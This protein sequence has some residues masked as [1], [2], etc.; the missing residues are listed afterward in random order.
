MIAKIQRNL[1]KYYDDP[2][3]MQKVSERVKQKYID[4]PEIKQKLSESMKKS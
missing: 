1:R 2:E 4:N 3:Y